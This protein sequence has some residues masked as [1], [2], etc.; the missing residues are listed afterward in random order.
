MRLSSVHK[1]GADLEIKGNIFEIQHLAAF[2][3]P[4]IRTVIYFKGCPLNC[5]WCHNPESKSGKKQIFYNH[6]QCYLCQRCE[7]ICENKCHTFSDNTHIF[8]RQSCVT[9]GNCAK[10]CLNHALEE[11]GHTASAQELISEVLTD[12]P[13]FSNGGGLTV[14]GGE[15]LLQHDFLLELLKEAKKNGL[16]TAI[17]TSGYTNRSISEIN[18]YTDLWLY[19]IKLLDSENHLK[20]TGVSN[21]VILQNLRL[22]NNLKANIVLRCPII[23]NINLNPQ[24]FLKI[25]NLSNELEC[26]KEIH[27][28]PYN[29]L[30]ISKAMQLGESQNY[31][32]SNFLSKE[33]LLPFINNQK[34]NPNLK[35]EIM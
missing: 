28:E 27:F 23:P 18:E 32:N 20:Y 8:S 24:H 5:A 4:G 15:P 13:F 29:P 10:N 34:F 22:L 7:D 31:K 30:G 6:K 33:D 17:E 1:W 12:K 16:H 9:C 35:I 2:D 26:V 14:S 3:G 21:E 11:C 25:A 19:D